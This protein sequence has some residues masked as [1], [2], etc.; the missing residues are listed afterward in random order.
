MA[1][2]N[3]NDTKY[4]TFNNLCFIFIHTL[5]LFLLC[6]LTRFQSYKQVEAIASL[7]YNEILKKSPKNPYA[8]AAD[9]LKNPQTADLVANFKRSVDFQYEDILKKNNQQ[10]ATAATAVKI[11]TSE[12][13]LTT[14][15]T[16]DKQ[17]EETEDNETDMVE[18]LHNLLVGDGEISY[19]VEEEAEMK[20]F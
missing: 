2:L 18:D 14:L 5:L 10:Y 1:L 19:V 11:A 7:L 3:Y 16:L 12:P 8:L 13:N 9:Y 15:V 20:V 17:T 4:D 6:C